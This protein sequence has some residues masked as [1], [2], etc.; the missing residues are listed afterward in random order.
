MSDQ[1]NS[2]NSVEQ[3]LLELESRQPLQTSRQFQVQPQ[4]VAIAPAQ[5]SANA[6]VS[7]GIQQPSPD[8]IPVL[9]WRADRLRPPDARTKRR[10]GEVIH[11]C[12]CGKLLVEFDHPRDEVS[13]MHLHYKIWENCCEVTFWVAGVKVGEVFSCSP[14]IPLAGGRIRV[15]R[16]HDTTFVGDAHNTMA[17]I[18][19]VPGFGGLIVLYIYGC[20]PMRFIQVTRCY[21]TKEYCLGRVITGSCKPGL[22]TEW[23]FDEDPRGDYPFYTPAGAVQLGHDAAF[24]D[25]PGPGT[26]LFDAAREEHREDLEDPLKS[27]TLRQDFYLNIYCGEE[28]WGALSWCATVTQEFSCGLPITG[29]RGLVERALEGEEGIP[30]ERIC[31]PRWSEAYG[32]TI[33]SD[34]IQAFE[35][36][37]RNIPKSTSGGGIVPPFDPFTG[38]VR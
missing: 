7:V 28:Y 4:P 23:H 5:L 16:I 11:G 36:A 33:N 9:P 30:V 3:I 19:N 6:I 35:A 12:E 8:L 32:L 18:R 27:L 2:L 21:V 17:G 1:S 15:A 10:P 34:A 24:I 13:G 29:L 25:N 22:S 20:W 37:N 14:S 26:A 38:K 31:E